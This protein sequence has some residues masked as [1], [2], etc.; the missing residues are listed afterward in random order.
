MKIRSVAR[1]LFL[2]AAG[3]S[4]GG[5]VIGWKPAIRYLPQDGAKCISETYARESCILEIQEVGYLN[6]IINT[7]GADESSV[8]IRLA[9]NPDIDLRWASKE[10]V[11]VDLDKGT[12]M[13]K[14][15]LPIK[16]LIGTRQQSPFSGYLIALYGPYLEGGFILRQRISHVELRLP[17]ILSSGKVIRATRFRYDDGVR[18][19]LPFIYYGH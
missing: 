7:V 8:T 19:P 18:I 4:C 10:L 13:T 5:C 14:A 15:V 11:V 9:P 3:I 12:T 6:V 2:V 16:S 17:D 1:A